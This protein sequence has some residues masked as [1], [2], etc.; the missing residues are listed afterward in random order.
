MEHQKVRKIPLCNATSVV[1]RPNTPYIFEATPGCAKCTDL[2]EAA[3]AEYGHRGES[4]DY[5]DPKT[6][7]IPLIAR[8]MKLDSDS[9]K[10][11][12]KKKH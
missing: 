3:N 7:P 8:P 11:K 5:T 1:L 10:S 6:S 9:K 2:L 4:F 12:G